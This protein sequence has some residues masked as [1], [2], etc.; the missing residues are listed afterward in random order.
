MIKID[1]IKLIEIIKDAICVNYGGNSWLS[2]S[3]DEEEMLDRDIRDFLYDAIQD[4]I[5]DMDDDDIHK[6]FLAIES[7]FDK[8]KEKK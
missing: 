1:E 3:F 6:L 8:G 4:N 7:Y 2:D 5:L